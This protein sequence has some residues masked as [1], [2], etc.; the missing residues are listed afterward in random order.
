[1]VSTSDH[2]RTD[3]LLRSRIEDTISLCERR[4]APVFFG[5]LDEAEQQTARQVLSSHSQ[6]SY[7][8][9]GGFDE[10]ERRILGVFPDFL[11]PDPTMFPLERIVLSYRAEKLLTHRDFLGTLLS[12]GVKRETIGDILC[13]ETVTVVFLREEVAPYIREQLTKVGGVGVKI[14]DNYDG[15]L[16]AVHAYQPL[17]D[18]VASPRLDAVVKALLRC[19]REKASATIISGFVSVDHTVSTEVARQLSAPCVIS[20]RGSGRFLIDQIGPP[21]KKGR[22]YLNARK[23]V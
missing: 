18:T 7:A 9:F 20:V 22:L 16:P 21:T 3:A 19:S 17:S 15:A 2:H 12:L 6:D 13:G 23:C 10:A 1:M 4:S 11:P 8:F 14:D 5:F